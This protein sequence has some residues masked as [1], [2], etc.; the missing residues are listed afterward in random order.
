MAPSLLVAAQDGSHAEAA[1][2]KERERTRTG[3]RFRSPI[4]S[5]CRVFFRLIRCLEKSLRARRRRPK[6]RV[7]AIFHLD[8]LILSSHPLLSFLLFSLQH[9]N[10]QLRSAA[11]HRPAP[12]APSPGHGHDRPRERRR[13]LRGRRGRGGG[14]GRRALS[15]PFSSVVVVVRRRRHYCCCCSCP[16]CC[17]CCRRPREEE[18]KQG[19]QS[20]SLRFCCCFFLQQQE[21]EAQAPFERRRRRERLRQRQKQLFPLREVRFFFFFFFFHRDRGRKGKRKVHSRLQFSWLS[22]QLKTGPSPGSAAEG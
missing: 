3:R 10:K 21:E 13:L 4:F 8:L 9:H 2:I 14:G 1:C 18:G 20:C 11:P 6:A 12:S 15:F 5:S 16:C 17:C 7:P 22:P 19:R